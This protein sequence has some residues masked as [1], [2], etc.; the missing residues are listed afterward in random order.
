MVK[1]KFIK[2]HARGAKDSVTN[3]QPSMADELIKEGAVEAVSADYKPEVKEVLVD[4]NAGILAPKKKAKKK[5]SK[6]VE[7]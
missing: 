2:D 6:K 1:V 7:K 3:M 4:P 5:V